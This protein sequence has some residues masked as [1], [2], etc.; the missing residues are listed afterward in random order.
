MAPRISLLTLAVAALAIASSAAAAKKPNKRAAARAASKEGLSAAVMKTLLA[1]EPNLRLHELGEVSDSDKTRTR[2][3][4]TPAHQ[5]AAA[6]IGTWMKGAGMA[7]SV[8]AVGNV[9]GVLKGNGTAGARRWLTGSHF[10]TAPGGGAFDG[11]LGVVLSIAAVETAIAEAAVA[12]GLTTSA[13]LA[14]ALAGGGRVV[15][16]LPSGFDPATL[17]AKG[18]EVVAF[19]D[20]EGVRFGAPMASSKALIGAYEGE[21]LLNRV[22]GA[23]VTVADALAKAGIKAALAD[24]AIPVTDVEG[25][26]EAHIEQYDKLE[27]IG[28]PVGI[29]T[30]VA[31]ATHMMFTVTGSDALMVGCGRE[32]RRERQ[33]RTARLPPTPPLVPPSPTPAPCPWPTGATRSSASPK[34]RSPSSP[35]A[36]PTPRVRSTASSAASTL[37]PSSPT[38]PSTSRARPTSRCRSRRRATPTGGRSWTA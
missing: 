29:V 1:D 3:Y 9:R 25:Y 2:L 7:V 4:L 18:V 14:K 27:R 15:D 22:D 35:G 21:E 37:S 28:S 31:G 34:S 17:L 26:V 13:K 30:H 16:A 10:D 11:A 24:A 36:R 23:G 38:R 12:K 32:R 20:Q 19:A 8:D 5:Q 6:L 33:R